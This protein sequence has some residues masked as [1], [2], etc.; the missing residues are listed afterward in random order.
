MNKYALIILSISL[1]NC[2]PS[3][4]KPSEMTTQELLKSREIRK[5]SDIDIL[6]AAK[7]RGNE[8]AV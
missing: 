6:E 5:I 7:K 4:K 8:L 3:G 1:L 2:E